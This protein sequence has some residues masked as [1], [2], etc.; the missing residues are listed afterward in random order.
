MKNQSSQHRA[1]E[2]LH[3][4]YRY[5]GGTLLFSWISEVHASDPCGMPTLEETFSF[6]SDI[7]TCL[8]AQPPCHLSPTD[9]PRWFSSRR[10]Y[11]I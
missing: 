3:Q 5:H 2:Q 6:N 11:R 9:S 4:P 10:G 8:L 1:C 7:A